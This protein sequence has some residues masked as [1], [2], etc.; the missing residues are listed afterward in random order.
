VN[1]PTP[2]ANLLAELSLISPA[3][4][5]ETEEFPSGAVWLDIFLD[6]HW[7]ILS[8]GPTSGIGVSDNSDESV[9]FT[10]HDQYFD[11]IEEAGEQLL[12]M[13]RQATSTPHTHAA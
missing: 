13:L 8:S 5:I 9:A 10:Q 7:F 2:I 6:E 4:K 3:V 1:L 11:T 12:G